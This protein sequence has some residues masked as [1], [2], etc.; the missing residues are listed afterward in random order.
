MPD[1]FD[2]VDAK[3]IGEYV[4]T[5][6]GADEPLLGATLFPNKK[7]LGLDIK[8][9][10]GY[11]SNAIA[12]KPSALGARA[13]VRDRIGGAIIQNEL[14]F[15][16]EKMVIDERLRQE[17]ARAKKDATDPY[18]SSILEQIFDDAKNLTDG[19]KVQSEREIMQMLFTGKIEISGGDQE[20]GQPNYA[21]DYD[22]DGNWTK[23]NVT[24]LK[25]TAKWTDHENSNPLQDIN[26]YVD[27]ASLAGTKIVRA[28][29][30]PKVWSDIMQNKN[31][32]A[33]FKN[34]DGSQRIFGKADVISLIETVTGVKVAVY[35]KSF[36]D[37]NGVEKF[38][39]PD[40]AMVFMPSGSLGSTIYGTTPEEIDLMSGFGNASVSIVNTGIAVTTAK[41]YGPPVT[42]ETIVSEL[43]LPSFE[44]MA[45]VFVINY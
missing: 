6:E 8:F 28:I 29:C 27:K 12:L 19:A 1:I 34:A 9:V 10:K 44:R 40:S 45:E 5:L 36:V 42:V 20:G 35:N 38:Y 15:F 13:F 21:Y 2:L 30:G 33:M 16:R 23:K 11:K 41:K 17:L 24:T 25:G 31:I 39:C 22:V 32:K 7:V 14:P 18:T 3:A 4:T 43:V 26:D 37:E